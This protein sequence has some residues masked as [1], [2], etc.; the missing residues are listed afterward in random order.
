MSTP[1]A[2]EPTTYPVEVET[3]PQGVYEFTAEDPPE[4]DDVIDAD[5]AQQRPLTVRVRVIH[6]EPDVP[7][8]IHAVPI[9]DAEL[10]PPID[11][12]EDAG[13]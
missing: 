6:I 1:E 10:P 3:D 5:D 9:R 12:L 13:A 2:P 4:I 8:R 11:P 7:F